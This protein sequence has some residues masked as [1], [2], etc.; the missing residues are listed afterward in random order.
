MGRNVEQS[1]IY[2]HEDRAILWMRRRKHVEYPTCQEAPCWC[3]DDSKSCP[4]HALQTFFA[5]FAVGEAPFAKYGHVN[6]DGIV[7]AKRV[8]SKALRM[9][10]AK[11]GIAHAHEYTSK[12]FRR[13]HVETLKNGKGRL[14]EI[15]NAGDW[16]SSA[17]KEYLNAVSL[18]RDALA[19]AV[20]VVAHRQ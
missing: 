4:A 10:L 16:H 20:A 5:Q 6:R 18:Q 13:G 14:C 1:A 7:S 12:A 17:Y 3:S 8:V 11:V 2:F 19:G 15:F 9:A